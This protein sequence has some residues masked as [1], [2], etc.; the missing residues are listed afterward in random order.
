[1]MRSKASLAIAF[2]LLPRVFW[3]APSAWHGRVWA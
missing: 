1:M 3:R 2:I